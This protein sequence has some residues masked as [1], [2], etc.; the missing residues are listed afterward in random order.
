MNAIQILFLI[1]LFFGMMFFAY[2]N[3]TTADNGTHIPMHTRNPFDL[4]WD[5]FVAFVWCSV[6]S[7]AV[8]ILW[9]F[10]LVIVV[11]ILLMTGIGM[12]FRK[13]CEVLDI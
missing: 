12:G 7:C 10:L 9:H 13:A 3:Y 1:P 8:V 11:A 6:L 5:V 4:I 2:T